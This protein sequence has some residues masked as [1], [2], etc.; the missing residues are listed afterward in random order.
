M[1]CQLCRILAV[2]L[3]LIT[4]LP[5]FA[6][7][8]D[9]AADDFIKDLWRR[10]KTAPSLVIIVNSRSIDSEGAVK[11][12]GRQVLEFKRINKPMKGLICQKS[13]T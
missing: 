10:Y 1:Q 6:V 8:A 2:V 9:Q 4:S 5:A 3:F 7:T 11:G 12:F 13:S